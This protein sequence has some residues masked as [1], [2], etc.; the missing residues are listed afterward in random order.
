MFKFKNLI[1][2]CGISL[3]L[4]GAP[5]TI[6]ATPDPSQDPSQDQSVKQDDQRPIDEI[7]VLANRIPTPQRQIATS[8]SV[9]DA[10]QIRLKGYAT[11]KDLLRT[12]P[13][14]SVRDSGGAGKISSLQI[15]GESG[16]RT[17]FL[18]DG[19]EIS[20][21]TGPQVSTRIEHLMTGS[22]IERIEILR[23]PQ[24]F[25]YGADAGG[26]VSILTKQAQHGFAGEISLEAGRYNS[27]NIH[28]YLTASN[29][30]GDI[31]FSVSD[32]QT[33]GFNART[34]DTLLTDSDGYDNTTLHL[35]AGFNITPTARVQLVVRD[36]NG[37]SEF[38][39]CFSLSFS[40][41]HD[42]EASF[43]QT[44][45]KL[46]TDFKGEQ[47][48]HHFAYAVSEIDND[49]L[50]AGISGF[51]ISGEIEKLEYTG[52]YL[53]DQN[54]SLSYGLERKRETIDTD[55]ERT[56]RDQFGLYI[57]YQ[58][59]LVENLYITAGARHDDNEDFGEHTSYRVSGAFLQD[60]QAGFSLK[61]RLS[62]GTGFRAPSPFEAAYNNS[63]FAA[64]PAQG[65]NLKEES[66]RGYDIGIEYLNDNNL[67]LKLVYF[68][69]QIED[70]I[71]FD[72]FSFS[73]YLQANGDSTSKGIELSLDYAFNSNWTLIAN[74]TLNKAE[75]T[76][77]NIRPRSPKK[78]AN[79]GLEFSSNN[80]QLTIVTNIRLAHDADSIITGQKL[81]NHEVF[82]LNIIYRP[83]ARLRVFAR[84]ENLGN[85]NYEEIRGFNTARATTYVGFSYGF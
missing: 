46:S 40:V 9:L 59:E 65:V 39:N 53:V 80:D 61:Y 18:I 78:L 7:V 63:F 51:K 68:N 47:L 72:S 32:Q 20:D 2:G 69:Q 3:S 45:T 60:F 34:N 37:D 6:A 83:Q 62:Y 13:G 22:D 36:V 17:L 54:T 26:V 14:I 71:F 16:F 55:T 77:G 43:D 85:V 81:D 12:Q 41:I 70:E 15:R 38:D 66:S 52:S 1:I 5:G 48:N 23:G 11:V 56:R 31:F 25:S 28:G 50:A 8:V 33:D 76:D 64:P 49:S 82:D 35:R 19:I 57:E 67:S 24:A 4:I 10:E 29:D 75:L 74:H 44:I 73:G 27:Q 84:I 79:L 42:C 58:D 21:P 30:L